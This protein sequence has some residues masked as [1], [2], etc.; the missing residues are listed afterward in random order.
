MATARLERATRD[1]Q[2][3]G[4]FKSFKDLQRALITPTSDEYGGGCCGCMRLSQLTW[5]E[6]YGRP[7]GLCT[8]VPPI[9]FLAL[10]ALFFVTWLVL[11]AVAIYMLIAPEYNYNFPLKYYMT[12]LTSWA[13]TLLL[14]YLASGLFATAMAIYSSRPDGKGAAT[15]WFVSLTWMLQSTN[16]VIQPMVT[17]MYFTLVHNWDSSSDAGSSDVGSGSRGG[18]DP[19]QYSFAFT[20][21]GHGVNSLLTIADLMICRNRLVLAH[22]GVALAFACTYLI[23]TIVY[24]AT[25]GTNEDGVSPY[26]YPA[27]DWRGFGTANIMDDCN[28]GATVNRACRSMTTRVVAS[29]LILVGAPTVALL[30]F[31]TYLCRRRMRKIVEARATK[32]QNGNG[33]QRSPFTQKV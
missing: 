13:A 32:S 5:K 6:A 16:L 10:R 15:P 19:I 29:L 1:L 11:N 33:R 18:T 4:T 2:Y 23:F 26:I 27:L 20:F 12:K 22:F 30:C 24:F 31:G 8:T 25:G 7:G 9:C 17:C 3:F 21:V 28:Y 14:V